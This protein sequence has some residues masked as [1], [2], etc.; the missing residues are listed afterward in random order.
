MGGAAAVAAANEARVAYLLTRDR[1]ESALADAL[2]L[3]A[4]FHC[5]PPGRLDRV[6]CPRSIPRVLVRLGRLKGLVYSSDR[7]QPGK[8]RT[9]IHFLET[10]PVLASDASGRRLF[11]V[12]GNY[13][14][15]RNGIEG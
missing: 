3:F 14:V 13:R 1:P 8:P 7:G 5:Y 11:I 12:G 10:P 2:N 6:R 9:F 15:T 4:R